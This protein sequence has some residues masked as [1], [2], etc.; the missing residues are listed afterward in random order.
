[1]REK[2]EMLKHH[3]DRGADRIDAFDVV[4]QFDPVNGNRAFLVMFEPV[5]ATDQR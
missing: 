1:M 5:D 4:V 2:I 3:A